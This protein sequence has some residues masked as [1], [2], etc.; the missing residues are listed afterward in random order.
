MLPSSSYA[1][2]NSDN[3]NSQVELFRFRKFSHIIQRQPRK[4][5]GLY[6]RERIYMETPFYKRLVAL[7][8]EKNRDVSNVLKELNL[9]TSKGTA[10]KTGTYPRADQLVLL[11]KYFNVS[12]DYLS[13]LSDIRTPP[14][15]LQDIPSEIID[16]MLAYQNAPQQI[17][18]AVKRVL[19]IP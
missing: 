3:G 8:N 5:A 18:D 15:K 9:S 1:Y 10:W 17:Q 14:E 12:M 19:T 2:C 4:L 11:C 13:G 16:L 7:C 6:K